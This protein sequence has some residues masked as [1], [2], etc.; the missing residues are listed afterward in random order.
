MDLVEHIRNKRAYIFNSNFN[1]EK[2]KTWI[3]DLDGV[4]YRGSEKI[5]SCIEFLNMLQKKGKEV[6]FYSNNSSRTPNFY[7]EKI[8]NMGFKTE[9]KN[10]FTSSIIAAHGLKKKFENSKKTKVYIIGENGLIEP[11]RNIGFEILND[12]INSVELTE[13]IPKNIKADFVIAGIDQFFTYGKLRLATHFIMNGSRFFGTNSDATVPIGPN[14]WPG[15]GTM[16]AAISTAV[17]K[18]PETIFGKPSAEGIQILINELKG[19]KQNSVMIGDRIDTDILGSV[20]A[21]INSIMVGTGVNKI[22]DLLDQ[23]PIASPDIYVENLS[24]LTF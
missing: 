16:I 18:P 13:S 3:F 8:S 12:T 10:V 24:M 20:N 11:M 9:P 7:S 6:V 1:I 21:N 5:D 17:G 15:A 22:T 4:V 19:N 23:K 14:F 2:I